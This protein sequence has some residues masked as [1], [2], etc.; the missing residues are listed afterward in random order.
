MAELL[1]ISQATYTKME[2]NIHEVNSEKLKNFAEKLEINKE[3]LM[4]IDEKYTI[5]NNGTAHD[6]QFFVH[7]HNFS[8]KLEQL[9]IDKIAM[10][11]DKIKWLEAENQRLRGI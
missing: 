3:D 6:S 2:R 8:E 4:E 9:Y 7:N 10:L 5:N 11:E 1:G